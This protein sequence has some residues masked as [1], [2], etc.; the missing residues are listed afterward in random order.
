MKKVTEYIEA[1]K[2]CGYSDDIPD[3]VPD[4]LMKLNYAPSYKTIAIAILK[5][6]LNFY[7]L[8]FPQQISEWYSALKKVEI[9]QR[10]NENKQ[11]QLN[12]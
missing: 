6:D 10:E 8:G 9:E 12:L 3:E 4:E 11:Y 5:N 2:Q 7:S 1:W